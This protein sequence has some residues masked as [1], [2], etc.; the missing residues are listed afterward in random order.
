VTVYKYRHHGGG[1]VAAGVSRY[2]GKRAV[3]I[4]FFQFVTDRKCRNVYHQLE[5]SQN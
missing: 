4:A 3:A 1:I 2:A 5:L